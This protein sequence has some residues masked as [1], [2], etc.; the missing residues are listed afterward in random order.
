MWPKALS[1]P[2]SIRHISMPYISPSSGA[3]RERE[4]ESSHW[5]LGHHWWV[6]ILAMHISSQPLHSNWYPYGTTDHMCVTRAVS[7]RW[8]PSFQCQISLWW[9]WYICHRNMSEW[10]WPSKDFGSHILNWC[11]IVGTFWWINILK[12]SKRCN[13]RF[14]SSEVWRFIAGEVIA[15]VSK[16]PSWHLIE[17]L[18]T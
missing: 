14:W 15:D 10:M 8:H 3:Q 5:K 6:T 12:L 17:F 16:K 9:W 2:S 13:W 18:Q 11:F 4:R 1:R 7:H